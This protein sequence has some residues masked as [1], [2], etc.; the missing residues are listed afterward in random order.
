MELRRLNAFGPDL[1]DVVA[2]AIEWIRKRDGEIM[3]FDSERLG[4]SI[5]LAAA[6]VSPPL[7]LDAVA[8]LA[9]MVRHFLMSNFADQL[10]T[11]EGVADWVEKSL[12]ETGHESLAASYAGYRRQ[13]A[14]AR[15]SLAV[16]P[17]P[18]AATTTR[19]R[20]AMW[21]KS[22]IVQSLRTHLKLEVRRSREIASAVERTVLRGGFE[23][24]TTDLVREVVNN[25]LARLGVADRLRGRTHIE[26]DVD[27]LRHYL[28][29]TGGAT[30]AN[31]FVAGRVWRDF[32]LREILSREVAEAEN[33]GLLRIDGLETPAT[34][35]AT[36]VDCAALVRR[37]RGATDSIA[38]FGSRVSRTLEHTAPLVAIDHVE[39]WL[40]ALAEPQDSPADLADL[41]WQEVRSRLRSAPV[42]CVINLYGGLGGD[43][44]MELG[45]GPL[46]NEQP[47]AANHEFAGAVA[48]EILGRFQRDRA[49]WPNLRIDWHWAATADPVHAA[50]AP[51]VARLIA[52]GHSLAVVFD[53]TPTPVAEGLRRCGEAIRPV[54]D[55]VGVSL[56]I[57][58]RDAGSPRSLAAIEESIARVA[59]LA[60]RGAL[61]KREFLRRLPSCLELRSLDQAALAVFPVGLDWT[62]REMVGHSL[63]EDDGALRLAEAMVRLLLVAAEREAK[64]FGLGVVLDHRIGQSRLLRPN[65]TGVDASGQF[66]VGAVSGRGAT[67]LRQRIFSTGRLHAAAGAGTLT[68]TRAEDHER[69]V[70]ALTELMSWIT[71]DTSLV[72]LQFAA[73]DSAAAQALVRWPVS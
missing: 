5:D 60:V 51:R 56:P 20:P 1:P 49:E 59:A 58:W 14:W 45:A 29:S 69:D 57:M 61:Q 11:T 38:Q 19:A 43:G 40:T 62:V 37:S 46:F 16:H 23:R 13:K 22:E 42:D 33:R 68:C 47:G 52:E 9:R 66:V 63:A 31:R 4:R 72:R 17:T 26:I 21:D 39:G 6:E 41:F 35:A 71:R 32:S 8:E 34:L 48:Q 54:L 12:R 53:R 25:E 2:P 36:C 27:E 70:D 65:A 10:V 73:G 55:Y 24:L 67:G 44:Y 64:H 50:L 3:R 7:P 28:A 15:E 30:W 18:H